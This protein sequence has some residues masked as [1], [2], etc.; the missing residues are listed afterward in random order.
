M[1]QSTKPFATRSTTYRALLTGANPPLLTAYVSLE[2]ESE[3]A[4]EANSIRLKNVRQAA[5]RI[6]SD[7]PQESGGADGWLSRIDRI[8]EQDDRWDLRGAALAVFLDAENTHHRYLP[9]HVDDRV[10]FGAAYYLLPALRAEVDNESV[11]LLD[12]NRERARLL[13]LRGDKTVVTELADG[14]VAAQKP[15]EDD[16]SDQ[17]Q[18]HTVGNVGASGGA[19][20]FHGQGQAEHAAEERLRR[21]VKVVAEK[22]SAEL[23]NVEIP[24]LFAGDDKL[25]GLYRAENEYTHFVESIGLPALE[26]DAVSSEMR[27]TALNSM[28]ELN[29]TAREETVGMV[30]SAVAHERGATGASQ[31]IK[32][33]QQ[34]R[35]EIAIL[36]NTLDPNSAGGHDV[37][38][39]L[40]NEQQKANTAVI[41]VLQSGGEVLVVPEESMP[42]STLIA[43]GF[44]Y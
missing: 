17:L 28:R 5:E 29:A 26:G 8:A 30:K 24:L 37:R 43:A 39:G 6:L 12:M 3:S 10:H 16:R 9:S 36:A 38:T 4:R 13:Y 42:D 20:V 31:I 2:H 40:T 33:A 44:R 18:M 11:L 25:L 14:G 27:E 34:G 41:D 21:W 15:D 32:A 23:Q 35:V 19:A 7:S 22:V 1:S